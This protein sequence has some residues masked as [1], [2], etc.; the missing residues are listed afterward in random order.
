MQP[1]ACTLLSCACCR[2]AQVFTSLLPGRP[3]GAPHEVLVITLALLLADV[4]SG[5]AEFTEKWCNR[6]IE[7]SEEYEIGKA[8]AMPNE[9]RYS[10]SWITRHLQ[11]ITKDSSNEA[12]HAIGFAFC[13]LAIDYADNVTFFPSSANLKDY[14]RHAARW[15][16][17][18]A[19]EQIQNPATELPRPPRG[20]AR[21]AERRCAA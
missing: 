8:W 5:D 9:W 7:T 1:H 20:D 12:T 21:S 2:H 19:R 10:E 14:F 16:A 11:N 4:K 17:R 6:V 13:E 18:G 3:D 15:H